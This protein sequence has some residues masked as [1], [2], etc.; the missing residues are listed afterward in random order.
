MQLYSD[1]RKLT[2]LANDMSTDE[3]CELTALGGE[4]GES[5]WSTT[6]THILHSINSSQKDSFSGA[7]KKTVKTAL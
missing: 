5:S 7:T 6:E 3:P 4:F 2:S 1:Q